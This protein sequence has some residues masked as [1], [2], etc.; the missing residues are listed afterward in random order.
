MTPISFELNGREIRVE[1]SA[2]HTTLLEFVRAQGLTGSKEGC[3]EGECGACTVL[4]VNPHAESGS[5]LVPVNSCLVLLPMAAGRA[6]FTV[7]A[8]ASEGRLAD[9]QRAMVEHG[10][11]QCGYCTPGFIASMFAEQYRPDRAGA[12]DVHNLS[13]NLCRCT[14]YRPIRDALATIGPPTDERFLARLSKPPQ[15]LRAVDTPGFSRPTSLRRCLEILRDHPES[16]LI[17][18][19]TDLAVESNLRGRR[20]PHLVSIDGLEELRQFSEDPT[21]VVIGAGV[22]LG[23]LASLW[24]NAP[25]V[26]HEWLPLFASP[27]IRNRATL[28]G[29]L[30]TAS[31]IGDGAP[32]LLALDARVKIANLEGERFVALA[33]FFKGYR[34]THLARGEVLVSIH[35]PKP[36]RSHA[37]F[38]KVAKRR[39]DDISTIAAAFAIELDEGHR[40]ESIRLAYGG[41]AAT[42][43][44]AIEAEAELAGARWNRSAIDKAKRAIAVT[45]KPISDHRGSAAYRLAMAQSLLDKFWYEYEKREE[46]AA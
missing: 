14:G 5:K 21:E 38:F 44:R 28:G 45:V 36:L 46:S 43:I 4:F 12:C 1:N 25:P 26:V 35:I 30:A 24:R 42:P 3:A 32:L 10:G 13:G 41:V 9:V 33:D 19:A 15:P 16:R 20:F 6:V 17:A 11:S 18:G 39:M 31:P 7:E 37:R 22:P 40:V 29:N 34:D 23:E 2:T 8:L 27:L